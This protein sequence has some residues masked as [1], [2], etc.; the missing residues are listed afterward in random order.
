M[1][2]PVDRG[3]AVSHCRALLVGYHRDIDSGRATAGIGAFADDAEFEAHGRV[4]RGRAEILDFLSAREANT[5]RQTVHVLANEVVTVQDDEP[6]GERVELRTVVLLHV[7]QPDGAYA[8]DRVLETV[9]HFSHIGGR[10]RITRRA[11]AP[12]HPAA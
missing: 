9:H 5:G 8:L 4:F 7:R 3:D 1:T 11:S 12:L 6:G 10:W 2:N